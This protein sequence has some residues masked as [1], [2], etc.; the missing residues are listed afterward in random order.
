MIL[1]AFICGFCAG[2]GFCVVVQN[3]NNGGGY[4]W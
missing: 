1:L 2:V 3:K 4:G